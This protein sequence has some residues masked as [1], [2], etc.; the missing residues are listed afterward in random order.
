MNTKAVLISINPKWCK[1]IMGGQKTV[2]IRK[3]RP[4]IDTSFKCYI[5]CSLSGAKE[6]YMGL[7]N[8]VDTW[9]EEK[10]YDKRGKVIGEFVCDRISEYEMEWYGGY[11]KDTYQDIRGIY[12]DGDLERKVEVL[13]ASNEMTGD[14]LNKCYLL[15]D[16]CLSFDDIGEYVCGKKDLGFH[17]FYGWH[18]SDLKIY[19]TPKE[20]SEFKQYNG[21]CDY[22]HLGF[23][24]PQSCNECDGCKVTRPPQSWRY[25]KKSKEAA[26]T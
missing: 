16:S 22:E 4:K 17:T 18:I 14:E 1:L 15:A 5:Y 9:Y 12:Y 13:V 19:D 8:G 20:L 21:Q 26:K 7:Q 11:A 3:S 10:W 25:V 2:E 24:I 23:A 6:F